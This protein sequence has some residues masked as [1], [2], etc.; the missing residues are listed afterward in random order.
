MLKSI[1]IKPCSNDTAALTY[2][3]KHRVFKLGHTANLQV[4]EVGELRET[5]RYE[6]VENEEADDHIYFF[7]LESFV[8]RA[9][10]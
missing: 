9:E 8:D 5:W 6:S 3:S 7:L 1:S 10:V 4:E 2:D